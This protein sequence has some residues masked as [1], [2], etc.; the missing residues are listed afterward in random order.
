MI[1]ERLVSFHGRSK[2][3]K[4]AL[5]LLV[6]QRKSDQNSLAHSAFIKMDEDKSGKLE[7]SEV[8]N[9][10]KRSK[11]EKHKEMD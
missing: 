8:E 11:S 9:A 7:Y 4:A 5:N 3:R 2:L 10:L 1:I 6:K